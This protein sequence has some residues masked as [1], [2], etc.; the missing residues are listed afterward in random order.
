M[1]EQDP[2][3]T[4]D[5]LVRAIAQQP[6]GLRAIASALLAPEAQ[7]L[8][9]ARALERHC[10]L[11]EQGGAVPEQ[12]AQPVVTAAPHLGLTARESDILTLIGAGLQV[13]QVAARLDISVSSVNTYR[14]RIFR[15]MDVS[16][17]AALIRYA[18][19][20]GLAS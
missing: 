6:A 10:Q 1:S 18:I 15:K 3:L 12:S 8:D 16:S 4:A 7:R 17:N 14:T 20:N 19:L 11:M 5:S 9:L 2:F 13:K